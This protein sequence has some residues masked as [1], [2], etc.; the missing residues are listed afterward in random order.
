MGLRTERVGALP[1]LDHVLSRVGLDELLARFVLSDRRCRLPYARAIGVLLRSLVVEREPVYRQHEAVA[2]FAPDLFGLTAEEAEELGDDRIGR[3]LDRLFDADRGALLTEVLVA[4]VASFELSLDEFHADT[5]SVRFAG[6]YSAARGRLVRGKRAP[7]I[8][9]GYSKDHRPDLKQLLVVLTTTKDGAV[10]CLFRA[11][12]GNASDSRTHEETWDALCRLAGRKDFLYVADSKLCAGEAMD[13]LD[14]RGGRF[15]TVLPRSRFEDQWFRKWLQDN[16]PA[17]E[18]V[19]DRPHPRRRRGPRDRWSVL[20]APLPSKEGWPVVWVH[21]TLLA[22]RQEQTR[23][24]QLARAREDLDRLSRRL[25]GPR[26]RRRARKLV[27][28][29]IDEILERDGVARYLRVKLLRHEVHRFRQERPGR[30]GPD[31]R[32]HRTTRKLWRIESSLDDARIAYD[33]KS[34]GMYPLITNDRT[35]TP[36]DVLLAH[37]RQ[38]AIERRFA[39]LKGVLE[40]APAFLKN[41]ARI[42]AFFFVEFLA[43]LV[44]GLI[45]RE[46]RR[47]MEREGV[48]NLPLYP[49]ERRTRRPTSEQVLRLFA[50][51]A[52]HVVTIEGE[53]VHAFEPQLTPLQS[54]VLALLGVPETAFRPRT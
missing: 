14:R 24:Q 31:T 15:V 3:A 33:R 34:D 21:S 54:R 39:E 22:L 5:T 35:L 50:H 32:F 2:D 47:A 19:R 23:Q 9:Y 49:E 11:E 46:L 30:P 52:R 7:F 26:A 37:K 44:R 18:L 4:T 48:A 38:P 40:I 1:V 43:L 25:G 42:E 27:Q 12:A 28:E 36:A 41:E 29:E 6:L 8:T 51:V 13:H 10:P 20:R 16:E 45:E 17:W 53:D